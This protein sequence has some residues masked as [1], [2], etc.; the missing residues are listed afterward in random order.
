M[1]GY[2]ASKRGVVGLMRAAANW[3]APH[4]IRVN[5]VH[6][7]GVSTP[8]MSLDLGESSLVYSG[9]GNVERL[10]TSRHRVRERHSVIGRV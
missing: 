1:T 5:S 8:M 2:T 4:N 9:R 7:T 10:V 6:P 3:L